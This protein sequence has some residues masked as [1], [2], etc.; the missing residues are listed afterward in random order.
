MDG[1]KFCSGCQMKHPLSNFN[2]FSE[3]DD[4]LDY[5]CRDY[6]KMRRKEA[7]LSKKFLID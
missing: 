6:R 1:E 5:S 4:G 7:K 3:S 2:N